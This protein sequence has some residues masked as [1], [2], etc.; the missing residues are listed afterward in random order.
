MRACSDARRRSS[1]PARPVDATLSTRARTVVVIALAGLCAGALLVDRS[2]QFF[3][4]RDSSLFLYVA[5]RV[6]E[7]GVP[8][9]D[10]WDHKIGRASCRERGEVGGETE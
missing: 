1:T 2:L 4:G 8:Y 6:Q 3:I 10:V 9:R 7:G 5:R